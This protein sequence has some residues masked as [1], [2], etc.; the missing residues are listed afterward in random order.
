MPRF[1]LRLRSLSIQIL[2]TIANA[3]QSDTHQSDTH[4][5]DTHQSDTHQSD[6]HQS[7][8]LPEAGFP[9]SLPAE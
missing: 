4:Q 5:S 3:H 8:R 2:A 1:D 7:D 6:T 9:V